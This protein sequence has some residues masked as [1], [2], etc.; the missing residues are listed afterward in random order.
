M[1]EQEINLTE[2][3]RVMNTARR[4]LVDIDGIDVPMDTDYQS[5]KAYNA[6]V[7]RQILYLADLLALAEGLVRREYWMT[8]GFPDPLEE[9]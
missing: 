1:R 6:K 7:N 2:A 5:R 4:V 9:E 3:R 8:R